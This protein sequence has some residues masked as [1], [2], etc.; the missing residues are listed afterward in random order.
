TTDCGKEA[1]NNTPQTQS[2]TISLNKNSPVRFQAIGSVD[3]LH[4][5]TPGVVKKN[6]HVIAKV[7]TPISEPTADKMGLKAPAASSDAMA[8]SETPRTS[9]SPLTPNN[10]NHQINGLLLMYGTMPSAECNVNFCVPNATK[11]TTMAKQRK[12]S[13][14]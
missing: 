4:L 6:D 9:A 3:K 12:D 5:T 11:M 8:N 1:R 14:R 7:T 2:K 10:D 13:R